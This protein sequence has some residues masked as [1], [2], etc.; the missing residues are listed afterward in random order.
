MSIGTKI[1]ADPGEVEK[2]PVSDGQGTEED[3][4]VVEF[5]KDDPGNPMNWGSF[6]K[7][8]ITSV[9]TTSVFAVTL[10]S[11]AY[12][13]SANEVLQDFVISSEVFTLG[14]SLFVLGFAIGPALWGP[15]YVSIPPWV[16]L[17]APTFPR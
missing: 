2:T 12:S 17:V 6:R 4:F 13:F 16:P 11:S 10:T 9:A 8:F 5:Q 3:P 7:W 1:T 14:L 15:L